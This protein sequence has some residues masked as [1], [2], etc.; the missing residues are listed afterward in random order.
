MKKKNISK[1]IKDVHKN[2]KNILV[3]DNN[4][5]DQT[6]SKV[7]NFSVKFTNHIYNLGKSNSIYKLFYSLEIN[8]ALIKNITDWKPNTSFEN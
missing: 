8:N 6:L 1:V 2:F 7:R 3:I 5:E 4:S